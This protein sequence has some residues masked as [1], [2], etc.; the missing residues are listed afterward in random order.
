[1][2]TGNTYWAYGLIAAGIAGLVVLF[3]GILALG[4]RIAFPYSLSAIVFSAMTG[5]GIGLY[6]AHSIQ[7]REPDTATEDGEN[8]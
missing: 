5:A 4:W 2:R 1:M 8:R 3:A 7:A 6:F